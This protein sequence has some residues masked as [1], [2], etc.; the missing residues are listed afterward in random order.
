MASL[1]ALPGTS[2]LEARLGVKPRILTQ[3]RCRPSPAR[4]VVAVEVK[5]GPALRAAASGFGFEWFVWS[6]IFLVER[7]RLPPC[8]PLLVRGGPS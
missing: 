2:S 4:R 1:N 8:L 3:S 5:L 6:L 7:V